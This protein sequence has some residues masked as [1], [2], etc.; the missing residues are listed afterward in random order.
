MEQL[1]DLVKKNLDDILKD[2]KGVLEKYSLFK[3]KIIGLKIGENTEQIKPSEAPI[4]KELNNIL[5]TKNIPA[6]V[7][8]FTLA[9]D[10]GREGICTVTIKDFWIEVKCGR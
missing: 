1:E 3:L 4:L 8:E 9:E 6:H 10:S 7:V 5:K 2:T